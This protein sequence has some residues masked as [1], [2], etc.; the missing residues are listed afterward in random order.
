MSSGKGSLGAE[1]LLLIKEL[2]GLEA[3]VQAAEK[4]AEQIALGC[5]MS[6]TGQPPPVVVNS[7]TGGQAY[8]GESPEVAHCR[9]PVVLD[10]AMKNDEF[11]SARPSQ[12]CGA[13]ICLEPASVRKTG[14]GR[15]RSRPG[16][17]QLGA[18]PSQGSW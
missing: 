15:R 3:V 18:H 8:G 2:V 13:G 10:R 14:C 5:S 7:S 12:G 9:E 17:V 4:A 1:C 16:R 11:L 6:I